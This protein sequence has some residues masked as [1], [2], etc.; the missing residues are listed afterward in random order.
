MAALLAA[1]A[2]AMQFKS[3]TKNALLHEN[4]TFDVGADDRLTGATWLADGEELPPEGSALSA[5]TEIV[6]DLNRSIVDEIIPLPGM[7]DAAA[8][9]DSLTTMLTV[10]VILLWLC[11][12]TFRLSCLAIGQEGSAVVNAITR[13]LDFSVVVTSFLPVMLSALLLVY[14]WMCLLMPLM[15][16]HAMST[17]ALDSVMELAVFVPLL[18]VGLIV[19]HDLALLFKG[20]APTVRQ[21]MAALVTLFVLK[22]ADAVLRGGIVDILY[23][24]SLPT[25]Q[26]SGYFSPAYAIVIIPFIVGAVVLGLL[27]RCCGSG[28]RSVASIIARPSLLGSLPPPVDLVTNRTSSALLG[29]V[30]F[31]YPIAIVTAF[32]IGVGWFVNP[33][34]ASTPGPLSLMMICPSPLNQRLDGLGSAGLYWLSLIGTANMPAGRG[35]VQFLTGY[36]VPTTTSIQELYEHAKMVPTSLNSASLLNALWGTAF[37]PYND[38]CLSNGR[39]LV[40]APRKLPGQRDSCQDTNG[41]ECVELPPI[42]VQTTYTSG[43]MCS[44]ATSC[45]V[46]AVATISEFPPGCPAGYE[47]QLLGTSSKPNPTSTGIFH[48]DDLKISSG[49]AANHSLC[50]GEYIVRFTLPIS[51]FF[52]EA[53]VE[54]V[55][56]SNASMT[57]RTSHSSVALP[58]YVDPTGAGTV[59]ASISKYMEG[60]EFTTFTNMSTNITTYVTEHN[61]VTGYTTNVSTVTE[62]R[63]PTHTLL[64]LTPPPATVSGAFDVTLQLQ[65]EMGVPVRG[66]IVQAMLMAPIG[67]GVRLKHGCGLGVTDSKGRV[68]L[69]LHVTPGESVQTFL[70]F[71]SK[72]T[73]SLDGPS[74]WASSLANSLQTLSASATSGSGDGSSLSVGEPAGPDPTP[75]PTAEPAPEESTPA[76]SSVKEAQTDT[77]DPLSVLK[78]CTSTNLEE[79]K[80]VTKGA[81]D[82]AFQRSLRL[83]SRDRD[84]A[85]VDGYVSAKVATVAR[86]ASH[87]LTNTAFARNP[88]LLLDVGGLL[89]GGEP[90]APSMATDI[91]SSG[92]FSST[93]AVQSAVSSAMDSALRDGGA[94]P[95][96]LLDS[97]LGNSDQMEAISAQIDQQYKDS[98]MEDVTKQ[99][100][101]CLNV[102]GFAHM[103]RAGASPEVKQTFDTLL[104]GVQTG[105]RT[106]QRELDASSPA[107]SRMV[108]ILK[109][110]KQQIMRFVMLKIKD[111]AQALGGLAGM[112]GDMASSMLDYAKEHAGCLTDKGGPI[113]SAKC[114]ANGAKPGASDNSSTLN[115]SFFKVPPIDV[116]GLSDVQG[117]ANGAVKQARQQDLLSMLPGVAQQAL[118]KAKQSVDDASTIA[119]TVQ[120]AGATAAAAAPGKLDAIKSGVASQ[121]KGLM[122]GLGSGMGNLSS[123]PNPEDAL[124]DI[125]QAPN[126]TG[127]SVMKMLGKALKDLPA[128]VLISMLKNAIAAQANQETVLLANPLGSIMGGGGDA[129]EDEVPDAL[130]PFDSS[131]DD[132]LAELASVESDPETVERLQ[133]RDIARNDSVKSL[134]QLFVSAGIPMSGSLPNSSQVAFYKVIEYLKAGSEAQDLPATQCFETAFATYATANTVLQELPSFEALTSTLKPVG[135]AFAATTVESV[136]GDGMVGDTVASGIAFL[137]PDFGTAWTA[138]TAQIS[139]DLSAVSSK[140]AEIKVAARRRLRSSVR[141]RTLLSVVDSHGHAAAIERHQTSMKRQMRLASS[142]APAPPP[143]QSGKSVPVSGGDVFTQDWTWQAQAIVT[144]LL[145]IGGTSAPPASVVY[146]NGTRAFEISTG[147]TASVEL[148]APIIGHGVHQQEHGSFTARQ[149]PIKQLLGDANGDNSFSESD[150]TVVNPGAPAMTSCRAYGYLHSEDGKFGPS[151][152]QKPE[153][154]PVFQ[155]R[156]LMWFNWLLDAGEYPDGSARTY[157]PSL[158]PTGKKIPVVDDNGVVEEPYGRTGITPLVFSDGI[159]G[160][161]VEAFEAGG[162]TAKAAIQQRLDGECPVDAI[163]LMRTEIAPLCKE[164]YLATGQSSPFTILEPP[165]QGLDPQRLVPQLIVRDNHG[166]P[167]PGR[168]CTIEDI[169]L[170]S[171]GSIFD[172]QPLSIS[173]Q[174]GPSDS[175][176]IITIRNLTIHGGTARRLKLKVTV[177]GVTAQKETDSKWHFDITVFYLSTEQPSGS[178]LSVLINGG[179]SSVYLFITASMLIMLLNA[180]TLRMNA[181]ERTPIAL[182]LLGLVALLSLSHMVTA[183]YVRHFGTIAQ[184]DGNNGAGRITFLGLRDVVATRS[185]N[186]GFEAK[187]ICLLTI[188]LS[189]LITAWVTSLW[190]KDQLARF[191]YVSGRFA[192][193]TGIDV[194]GR[195]TRVAECAAAF[196]RCKMSTEQMLASPF[197]KFKAYV[198][199]SESLPA[200]SIRYFGNLFVPVMETYDGDLEPPPYFNILGLKLRSI[201][202]IKA[203]PR[204]LHRQRAARN[205]VRK[206][207]RGRL[208]VREQLMRHQEKINVQQSNIVFRLVSIVMGHETRVHAHLPFEMDEDFFYPERLYYAA[209]LSIWLQTILSACFVGGARLLHA[210]VKKVSMEAN[211]INAISQA[212]V[213]MSTLTQMGLSDLMPSTIIILTMLSN[214]LELLGLA[215]SMEALY[216]KLDDSLLDGM[217]AAGW[218]AGIIAF[219]IH[220]LFWE[221]FFRRY[222]ARIFMMR[223]G[224]YFFPPDRFDETGASSF[225]GYVT[226]Y[227]VVSTAFI[228]NL[229]AAGFI[230]AYFAIGLLSSDSSDSA[231]DNDFVMDPTTDVMV[232]VSTNQTPAA[233]PLLDASFPPPPPPPSGSTDPLGDYLHLILARVH[234]PMLPAFL[235]W[236]VGVFAFQYV[237]NKFVWFEER[238]YSRADGRISNRWLKYRFWYAVYEY[239]LI[240]PNVLIGLVF[241]ILRIFVSYLLWN[242]YAF[243]IDFCVV[244]SATGIEWADAGHGSYVAVARNDHRYNNP[245]VMVFLA[246]LQEELRAGRLRRARIK[247][248]QALRRRGLARSLGLATPYEKMLTMAERDDDQTDDLI[249]TSKAVNNAF[250]DNY[251]KLTAQQLI[252]AQSRRRRVLRRWQ[253][254][255]MLTANPG[256]QNLR[257]AHLATLGVNKVDD[258]KV[259][260]DAYDAAKGRASYV[261]KPLKYAADLATKPVS[262][263]ITDMTKPV[264]DEDEY[265]DVRANAQTQHVSKLTSLRTEKGKQKALDRGDPIIELDSG[266][267]LRV[268][269]YPLLPKGGHSDSE[270]GVPVAVSLFQR[271]CM[272]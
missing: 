17:G 93:Q 118:A 138:H 140:I 48:F 72:G 235:W 136:F 57:T 112:G 29:R 12:K 195:R 205:Y 153:T 115:V 247:I 266:S 44:D 51:G 59:N 80:T 6:Y 231:P 189:L 41:A 135:G 184:E 251:S 264:L 27:M 257:A 178:H 26:M 128:R 267:S 204:A 3:V 73:Y 33:V 159:D 237:F 240:L 2:A 31:L 121:V 161:M 45:M 71:G 213:S 30:I 66:Q 46:E 94:Q 220:L 248:G 15:T 127:L 107:S 183:L 123:L 24:I 92:F 88:A 90:S 37:E 197:V 176:G 137:W 84:D 208:W 162:L 109:A 175:D 196:S 4:L 239:M 21:P 126:S 203:E 110:I 122:G 168:F 101:T 116:P 117:M 38:G 166:H 253:V 19:L 186:L 62:T 254:L 120:N 133:G 206:L 20:I 234:P 40:G 155:P 207:F 232:P 78:A 212:H 193:V 9:S 217:L 47:P 245:I 218:V 5:G 163:S 185:S 241:I 69:H 147:T 50:A 68:T 222:K 55:D 75:E 172:M 199:E 226:A 111:A 169:G 202:G 180:V 268:D 156:S 52:G 236:F 187:L 259:F 167:V 158:E 194:Y 144:G 25:I 39:V 74:F 151:L 271:V 258:S 60:T 191:V 64:L 198:A 81:C 32:T 28:V 154:M 148:T 229:L 227:M 119:D 272:E 42:K 129:T 181:Y 141:G 87:P 223:S 99:L 104:V 221:S 244:P 252:D 246:N 34:V 210:T 49:N 14:T 85:P 228:G 70:V 113:N 10:V 108:V 95:N 142:D 146:Y 43:G 164:S 214:M 263:A 200:R 201:F 86:K 265:D 56:F 250:F 114:I 35:A 179:H 224:Q 262:R 238:Q 269:R 171:D 242:F 77:R 215:D 125:M 132:L 170:D 211:E 13:T 22:L 97:V 157:C 225:I 76:P 54:V 270:Y 165:P 260:S 188:V 261:A 190:V 106:A 83:A 53:Q 255:R 149:V 96:G 67:S 256:L 98:L 58:G 103:A 79:R 145:G 82:Q 91:A 230:C 174:C 243:S 8:T 130:Q 139:A 131:F 105:I 134:N 1:V 216:H 143:P 160:T 209:C 18:I 124:K 36:D 177:D 219:I 65:T 7:L 192:V 102:V 16:G 23:K 100:S 173:A 182:R 61:S 89:S 249:D 233:A 11:G 63:K 152:A 150:L